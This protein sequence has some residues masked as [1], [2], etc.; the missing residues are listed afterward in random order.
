[1]TDYSSDS[2]TASDTSVASYAEQALVERDEDMRLRVLEES[3]DVVMKHH[4]NTLK[5]P[6]YL[7][8]DPVVAVDRGMDSTATNED[9]LKRLS[10]REK[11]IW[12]ALWTDDY[13]QIESNSF[14][15]T[16]ALDAL[17]E[18]GFRAAGGTHQDVRIMY[19][20]VCSLLDAR[21]RRSTPRAPR[22]I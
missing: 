14:L 9:V 20:V 11:E 13:I 4:D 22:I 17:I 2:S 18:V 6:F 21:I 3:I 16:D 5:Y 15:D 10:D 7:F 19:S 12:T 1:M 8:K